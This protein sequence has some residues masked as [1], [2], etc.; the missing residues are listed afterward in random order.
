MFDLLVKLNDV[1]LVGKFNN[2]THPI[3]KVI[4]HLTHARDRIYF[5]DCRR[6]KVGC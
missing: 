3:D 2:R 5:E 4:K 6:C 1:H